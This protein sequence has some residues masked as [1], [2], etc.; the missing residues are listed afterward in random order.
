MKSEYF[1]CPHCRTQL[2]KSAAASVLGEAGGFAVMGGTPTVPCPACGQAIDT[3]KMIEG[4]YDESQWAEIGNALALVVWLFGTVILMMAGY[5]FWTS[6]GLS[7]AA[8]IGIVIV[9]SLL[10]WGAGK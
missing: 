7:F 5:G 2:R 6:L 9:F 8:G 1:L 4:K 3:L 10:G